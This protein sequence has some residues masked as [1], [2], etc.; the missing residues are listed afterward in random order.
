[1]YKNTAATQGKV[2]RNKAYFCRMLLRP[3]AKINLGLFITEKRTDG[4]HNLETLFLP[5]P[6]EDELEL[7]RSEVFTFE[8]SGLKIDAESEGNLVVKAYRLMQRHYALPPVRILLNKQIPMGAGLGGGSADAAFTLKGLNTLFQLGLKNDTLEQHA[9]ELGSDCVFFIRNEPALVS[10]RGER[11]NYHFEFELNAHLLLVKPEI[12]ISTAE[13]YA[14]ISP[15]PLA[16]PLAN[17]V[18]KEPQAWK[19]ELRNDFELAL[20]PRYPELA[21]IKEKLYEMGAFY[22]AMSGSGSCLFGLFNEAPSFGGQFDEMT[23][24]CVELNLA[25]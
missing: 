17:L 8:S 19:H 12:F 22:A 24:K 18:S 15:K 25:I 10:G 4:Y 7:E 9:A 11:L 6:W 2:S 5:I 13:A 14:L 16:V 23:V 20:F 1:M 3:N 21:R